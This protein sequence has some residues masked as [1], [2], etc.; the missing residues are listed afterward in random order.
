M[1][2]LVA[3]SAVSA[4]MHMYGCSYEVGASCSLCTPQ[5]SG[6]GKERVHARR[7]IPSWAWCVAQRACSAATPRSTVTYVAYPFGS[8]LGRP[9]AAA[10]PLEV[11]WWSSSVRV[12]G[13]R[14][15][16]ESVWVTNAQHR[17]R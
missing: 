3:Y 16:R 15:A 13:P 8:G 6:A 4:R 1:R 12:M 11:R 7:S 10:D 5:Q 2:K 17:V 14:P 9:H